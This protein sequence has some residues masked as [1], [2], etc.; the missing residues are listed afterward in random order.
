M[1]SASDTHVATLRQHARLIFGLASVLLFQILAD[2][3]GSDRG[4]AIKVV[5]LRGDTGL[6]IVWMAASALL[7]RLVFIPSR[8]R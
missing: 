7:P 3:L 6:P 2:A 8:R 4:G 5:E 1:R